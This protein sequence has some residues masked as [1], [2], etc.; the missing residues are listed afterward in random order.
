MIIYNVSI[1]CINTT[2]IL[3]QT[4]MKEEHFDSLILIFNINYLELLEIRK[5][6]NLCMYWLKVIC[7]RGILVN[8]KFSLCEISDNNGSYIVFQSLNIFL[9]VYIVMNTASRFCSCLSLLKESPGTTE[10]SFNSVRFR[11][12]TFRF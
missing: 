2:L 1:T 4:T 5:C 8:V 11:F 6:L 10:G 7:G 9:R 12:K 3:Q